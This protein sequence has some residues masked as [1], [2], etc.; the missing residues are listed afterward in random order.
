MT[1]ET[2]L[3]E[4]PYFDDFEEAKN[5]HRVLFRPGYAVQARELTQLQTILQNQVERFANEVL[6]NG[7]VVSGVSLTTNRVNWV[8]IKDRDANNTLVI[9]ENFLT[10]TGA[11]A[12]AIVV[13]ETSGMI[14]RLVAFKQ[15]T[16]QAFPNASTIYVDYVN[17]GSNNTTK[18]FLDNETLVVKNYSSNA[19]IAAATSYSSNSTGVGLKVSSTDGIIYHKGTFIRTGPQSTI[20]GRYTTVPNVN[21]GFETKESLVNSYEDSS[22]YDNASGSTNAGAPGAD[23]LKLSPVLTTRPLGSSNTETFFTVSTLNDGQLT[24]KIKDTTYSDIGD[25]I[26]T[27]FFETN[28]NFAVE[29]FNIRIREHLKNSTNLGRYTSADGGDANKLV[30]SIED[31]LGYVGGK[32]TKLH[33]PVPITINKATEVETNESTVIGQ[34]IGSYVVCDELA[35]Q[36]DVQGLRGVYLYDTAHKAVSSTTYATTG[37][38]G[39]SIGTAYVRGVQ[40]NSGDGAS[41]TGQYRIYISNINMASGH[42]FSEVRSVIMNSQNGQKAF[43]DVVLESGDAKLKDASLSGLV[44]PFAQS[45]TK[46]L[47]NKDNAVETQFVFRNESTVTFATGGTATVAS[48]TAHSGGTNVMNDTGTLTTPDEKNIVIVATS[49]AETGNLAGT[50]SAV[51]TTDGVATVTGTS[52]TF[53]DQYVVG[54]MITFNSE[55]AV[56]TEIESQTS[57]KCQNDDSQLTDG[58]G[59]SYNHKMSIPNGKVFDLANR[60]TIVSTSTQHSISLFGSTGV[61]LTGTFTASVLY[62][63]L[64]TDAIPAAKVINKN[65]FVKV[66]TSTHSAGVNGPWSLGVSDVTKIRKVYKAASGVTTSS[67]DVTSH[68]ILDDGQKDTHY[69]TSR[70]IKKSTSSLDLSSSELLV[71]LDYFGRDISNG[72]G[73]L[74]MDSY[75]IDDTDPDASDKMA[76]ADVPLFISPTSGKIYDLRDSIDF[77]PY[78]TEVI[79]PAAAYTS[80]PNNPGIGSVFSIASTGAHTPTPDEN[81][82][83]AVQYYLPRKDRV[84]LSS[85]GTFEITQGVPSRLPR[86]P[87]EKASSMTLAILDVPPYPSLSPYVAKAKNRSDYQVRVNVENNRRYVMADIRTLDR[88]LK[89]VEYYSSLNALELSARNKQIFNGSG[90]DRFKNGFLVDNFV[91]HNVADTTREGYRAAIDK[92]KGLLR[93]TFQ[94]NYIEFE[95]SATGLV[96]NEITTVPGRASDE[97][98]SLNYTSVEY[99]SQPFATKQRN[100]VQELTF[101]WTGEVN[102]FP[103]MDNATDVNTL[104]DVQIDFDGMYDSFVELANRTGV[105]GTDWGGWETTNTDTDVNNRNTAGGGRVVTTT[106]Q[107]D[108][109]RNGV[110]TTISPAI[111]SFDLGTRTTNVAIRDYMRSKTI[112]FQGIRMRPN[113]RVWPFFDGEDVTAY[114]TPSNENYANTGSVGSELVTDNNGNVFG[115]FTIPN[116]DNLKFRIGSREFQLL[117]VDDPLRYAD[118]VTTS[119]KSEYTSVPLDVDQQKSIMNIKVP[120]FV[121]T[122]VSDSR[123]LTSVSRQV[124]PPPPPPPRR[125]ERD[126]D[127]RGRGDP[128]AQSFFVSAG[129]S[130]GI[131]MTELD[132]FFA[133]KS[134]QYPITVQIREMENGIPTSTVVPFGST[135]KNSVSVSSN[136]LTATTFTFDSPVFLKNGKD[137]CFVI[138]PAGN[139]D[140]Y[141]IWTAELGGTDIND[142]ML[143]DKAPAAGVMMT[144]SN[145]K[146]WSV[147]QKED[148]KFVIRKAEF[149]TSA[150][151]LLYLQN[152]NYE[153]FNTQNKLKNF[154]LGEKVTDLPNLTVTGITGN[155]TALATGNF[156]NLT[157]NSFVANAEIIS[158]D[159]DDDA[160]EV[161]LQVAANYGASAWVPAANAGSSVSVSG[162]GWTGTGTVDAFTPGTAVGFAYY[163]DQVNSKLHLIDSNGTFTANSYVV[164]QASGARAQIASIYDVPYNTLVPKLPTIEYSNTS[165]EWTVRTTSSTG[166]ISDTFVA[167][168]NGKTTEY[169]DTEKKLYSRSNETGLAAKNGTNKSVI[170]RGLIKSSDP[171]VSPIVDATRLNV[172]T[173]G[174]IINNDST[175]EHKE[176]GNAEVRHISKIVELSDGNEAEDIKVFVSAWKPSGTDVKVYAR[177][178]NPE[179]P[180]GIYEKDY[181]PLTVDTSTGDSDSVNREDFKEYEY[182][183]SA[184]TDG[185]NF[186]SAASANSHARLNTSDDEV[187]WYM[188]STGSKF[189][190]F[191]SFAIK[192]VMTSTGSQVVPL[193]RDM[194]V[195]ALQK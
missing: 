76:T 131:F 31:G 77:R 101:N 167:G 172:L 144:S 34:A 153:F 57:L 98:Y 122:A 186:L 44:F 4:S 159:S 128:L 112:K 61:T 97:T 3:N 109:I 9:E 80:A 125:R 37:L 138:I 183:F 2:N 22:L 66:T 12:N 58:S 191:K 188:N 133:K 65:K 93:P 151:G 165:V 83:T 14:G 69:A 54:D 45:G 51:S 117:D 189:N 36:F 11:L 10:S 169:L 49:T 134:E 43:A 105:T 8:R 124:I 70:L 1:L 177:I 193:V 166:V 152:K 32:R 179:D 160:G 89:N 38:S 100:P 175:D 16:E 170:I 129:D 50:I 149:Q 195:I 30:A 147:V 82:Q 56:I 141:R 96:S 24:S 87:E 156:I 108:Q 148:V 81:F 139:S 28:G 126:N 7:T 18:A 115:H 168:D 73:F 47:R 174:N 62:N 64:R 106:T 162:T 161:E 71:E 150:D 94:K 79:T 75:P 42:S 40:Y 84:V 26:D 29:P 142:S 25:Y 6:V 5:F 119:A 180:E 110:T 103:S 114:V 85:E 140:E 17:S 155:T 104:P 137:Y 187:V 132:L 171:N 20:A 53:Q 164:G 39:Q 182:S 157:Y 130:D 15:G 185:Q 181:T 178:H 13:G 68:F 19:F 173:V 123:T 67:E 21:I 33:A 23:R 176:V 55:S 90:L 72:T 143:V 60:G 127:D 136:G 121:D 95:S 146:T 158:I 74:C 52:T 190:G 41:P 192:I 194:R 102:L 107:T 135:T 86:V 154:I 113:T 27:K 48:N 145:D 120:Q 78:T 91:G 92:R 163:E 63:T 116:D 111:Q 59:L 184:N 99:V 35:G 88:R 118:I 46:T